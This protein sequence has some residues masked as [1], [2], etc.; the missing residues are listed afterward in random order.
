[1]ASAAVIPATGV[2]LRL[3]INLSPFGL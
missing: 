2:D 1:V 3:E